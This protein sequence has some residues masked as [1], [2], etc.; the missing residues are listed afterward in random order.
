MT[1]IHQ[2][3]GNRDANVALPGVD[4]VGNGVRFVKDGDA[5]DRQQ[6][7]AL[8][9][10]ARAAGHQSVTQFVQHHAAEN[11]ADQAQDRAERQSH[12]A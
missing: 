3:S 10:N 4:R 6:D 5:A 8:R 2:R 11:D 12:P 7:D 1:E 9:W